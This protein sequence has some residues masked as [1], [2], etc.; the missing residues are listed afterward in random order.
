MLYLNFNQYNKLNTSIK[1]MFNNNA[2]L[3][4]VLISNKRAFLHSTLASECSIVKKLS[5]LL[6]I[7]WYIEIELA[8]FWKT[9]SSFSMRLLKWL[10]H[11]TKA[12]SAHP[13]TTKNKLAIMYIPRAVTVPDDGL[14][15]WNLNWYRGLIHINHNDYELNW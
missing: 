6:L 12:N 1:I 14:C 13:I 2:V 15:A 3:S 8:P 9:L 11:S 7:S 4:I 10:R 5:S